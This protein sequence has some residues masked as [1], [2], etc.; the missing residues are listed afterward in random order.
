MLTPPIDLPDAVEVEV[1][2]E[3]VDDNLLCCLL[4]GEYSGEEGDIDIGE[5]DGTLLCCCDWCPGELISP[6]LFPEDLF[7][8]SSEEGENMVGDRIPESMEKLDGE[9]GTWQ[10]GENVLLFRE[11][12]LDLEFALLVMSSLLLSI[13][14]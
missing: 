1:F 13:Y 9:F 12:S 11:R 14:S 2:P 6:I 3:S 4:A 5:A 7:P 10:S 8:C